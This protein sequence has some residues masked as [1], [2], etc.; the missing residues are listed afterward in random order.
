MSEHTALI[1]QN[2]PPPPEVNSATLNHIS[3]KTESVHQPVYAISLS[4]LTTEH[5]QQLI[6]REED[7]CQ[8]EIA[9]PARRE[10]A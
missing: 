5:R 1:L 4:I 2:L 10:F 6:L 7:G 3:Q 9:W 8:L